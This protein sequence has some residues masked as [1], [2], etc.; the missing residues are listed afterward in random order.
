MDLYGGPDN[1]LNIALHRGLYLAIII[2]SYGRSHS[3]LFIALYRG[4]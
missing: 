1:S 3:A 4:N 2:D